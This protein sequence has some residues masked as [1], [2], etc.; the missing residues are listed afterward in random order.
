M[1]ILANAAFAQNV[2]ETPPDVLKQMCDEIVIGLEGPITFKVKKFQYNYVKRIWDHAG[3]DPN[4]DD[5]EAARPKIQRWW[6]KHKYKVV[7]NENGFRVHSGSLLKY[8]IYKTFPDLLETLVMT[9]NLD[10]NFTDISDGENVIDYIDEEIK[11][12]NP[13]GVNPNSYV[14]KLM[15]FRAK[16]VLFGGKTGAEVKKEINW[17][18]EDHFKAANSLQPDMNNN[19]HGQAVYYYNKAIEINPKFADAYVALARL[20]LM[21]SDNSAIPELTTAIELKPNN[22][23]AYK[24]RAANYCKQGKKVAAA[25]DEKKAIDLG[26]KIEKKCQQ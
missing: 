10:I 17:S 12:L 2:K 18:A 1:L 14:K 23:E 15:R 19:S 9:Y 20:L 7:C 13:S 3:A 4:V 26:G 16:L 11:R 6:N 21:E 24:L 22:I 25:A 8:S 5:D